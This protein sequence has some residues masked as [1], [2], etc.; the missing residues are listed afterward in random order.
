MKLKEYLDT[1]NK[2][3]KKYGGD[4]DMVYSS[5]DEGNSFDYVQY[6]PTVGTFKYHENDGVFMNNK[7][8]P[9]CICVN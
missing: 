8:K 1:L 6:N 2:H 4:L 5:D 3:Y 7:E 9:D